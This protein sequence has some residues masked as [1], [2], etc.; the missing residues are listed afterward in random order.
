MK[1]KKEHAVT[2]AQAAQL[3]EISRTTIK[4]WADFGAEGIWLESYE[5]DG[6][7]ATTIEA[8]ERFL[9]ACRKRGRRG[10]HDAEWYELVLKRNKLL[11]RSR[12][13]KKSLT[14]G[15]HA[16]EVPKGKLRT[17]SVKHASYA[18]RDAHLPSGEFV[19]RLIGF[20]ASM[21]G[22]IDHAWLKGRWYSH[23]RKVL[24]A[25]NKSRK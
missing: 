21:A 23:V 19:D 1:R 12:G 18:D 24:S 9:A 15:S 17:I 4:R 8:L 2:Y 25:T 13:S 7:F 14:D 5:L 6:D 16:D 11:L 3:V 22:S 20:P 10:I